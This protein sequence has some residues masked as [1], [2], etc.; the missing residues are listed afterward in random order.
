M[1]IIQLNKITKRYG[2]KTILKD[3][4]LEISKGDFVAFMGP[5]GCVFVA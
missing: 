1:S 2:K 3:F 4:S 5:S